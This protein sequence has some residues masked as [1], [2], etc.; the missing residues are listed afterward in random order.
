MKTKKDFIVNGSRYMFDFDLCHYKKGWSQVDTEQ[1][2]SYYGTW[3]NIDMLTIISYIE[4]DIITQKADS[5]DEFAQEL[6]KIE[7]WNIDSGYRFIGIDTF[8]NNEITK[9]YKAI[10]LATM[11]H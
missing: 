7:K 5:L 9:Q 11:L 3:A 8:C 1:D 4:G 2:C 6:R 10:G